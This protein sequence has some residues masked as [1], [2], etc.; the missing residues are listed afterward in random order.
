MRDF[1]AAFGL[2]SLWIASGVAVALLCA[3]SKRASKKDPPLG[4]GESI[5]AE[6]DW[7]IAKL[8]MQQARE[9]LRNAEIRLYAERAK[10]GRNG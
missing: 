9:Y 1:L 2:L 10:R 4:P 5:S 3:R 6:A 7:E 8:R